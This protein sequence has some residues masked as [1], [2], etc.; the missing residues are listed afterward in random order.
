M[1]KR[2]LSWLLVL[3]MVI[4]LIPSTLVT[5]A[6]AA[7]A[8]SDGVGI[9]GATA[10]ADDTNPVESAGVY[11]ISGDRQNPVKITAT[12]E[13]VLV[14]DG[15]TITTATSPIELGDGAKV[16]LVVKDN[17]TNVL[18]C[19]ATNL[20]TDNS[21]KTAGILVPETAVLT[22]DRVQGA[23]GTGSLT[24]TGGYGGA[25][26]GGAATLGYTGERGA[27]G[28]DGGNGSAGAWDVADIKGQAGAKGIGGLGGF[29]GQSATNAGTITI[30]AGTV[31]AVGGQGGAGIGGGRGGDGQLYAPP[32]YLCKRAYLLRTQTDSRV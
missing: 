22:I 25:G 29:Y 21:G 26:I 20:T 15:V 9:T 6:L 1:K 14:L 27:S 31:N 4:S 7:L 17:T 5:T 3:T 19:T 23:D 2:F 13:V 32:F 24:V 11:K 12:D 18:T 16:T 28:A 8:A 30:N 10:L